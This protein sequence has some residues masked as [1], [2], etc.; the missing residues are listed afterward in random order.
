MKLSLDEELK[1]PK[2]NAFTDKAKLGDALYGALNA[3]LQA[4]QQ[5]P[6]AEQM[7]RYRLS[8]RVGV[9]G[10]IEVTAE[11]IALLK[12]RISRVFPIQVIG[13]IVDKLE[14]L[15]APRLVE[16]AA[17]PEASAGENMVG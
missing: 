14:A 15:S 10:E 9:G 4:D 7:K 2:G 1:D 11:E 8:Q 6:L 13:A 5:L 12:E 3:P 17:Q 16:K